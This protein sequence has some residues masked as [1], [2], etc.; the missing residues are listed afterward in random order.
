MFS[1]T[2]WLL[3]VL[4]PLQ[5]FIGDQHGLNT[6]EHQPAKLAAIEAHWETGSSV[7]LILF[8]IPDD[9]AE[10][11]HF[12]IEVPY[13]GS[14]ILT[15]SLDGTVKGLKDFPADQRPPVALPFFAF[16]IMV[17]IGLLMLG[18]VDVEL[19]AALAGPLFE[20]RSSCAP[21]SRS[22]PLGFI[23]VLAGWTTTEVGR[24]PWIVYGLMRTAD[25]VSPSLTGQDV[26]M[27]LIFYVIVYLII[28]PA[29]RVDH[30]AHRQQGAGSCRSAGRRG[31]R[32]RAAEQA[33][34]RG[35]AR[36]GRG[37]MDSI[38]SF[39]PVW[40][41]I[42]A[43]G[44]FLYVLLDGFDLGVG[45]LYGFEPDLQSRNLVMNSIAPIWDGNE[46]W[47]V[48]GGLALARRLS[49]GFRDH[50]PGAVFPRAAHAA[51]VDIPRRRLRI[52]LPRYP[53]TRASGTTA[54]ATARRWRPSLKA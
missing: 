14:L 13:L 48:L 16:R 27:S 2:L 19:V 43:A 33:D 39:V 29:G 18:L 47:L 12:T 31:D 54:S 37:M 21:A 53:S 38:V 5:I 7:P 34:H 9:E 46:T 6:L 50:H 42:L 36:Q 15:H 45:I 17:G 30:G 10:T 24:Q 41:T 23:A 49:A 44:I 32:R 3:S 20:A 4:V 11:N 25:A 40:A 52:P 51:G 8:A 35:T 28:F 22:A 26:L 1:I